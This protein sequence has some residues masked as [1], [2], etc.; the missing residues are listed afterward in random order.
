MLPNVDN[1]TI[2]TADNLDV[3][4]ELHDDCIDL[5]YLD[6]PF[7]SQR[8]Y[9]DSFGYREDLRIGFDD[10][11]RM[12]A[13]KQSWLDEIEFIHPAVFAVCEAAKTSAGTGMQGYL[14]FMAI[15]IIE[16]RRILKPTG[17]IYLHCDHHASHYLKLMMDAIFGK[18]N[19]RNDIAWGYRTGGV[20]KRYWP[21]KHDTILFYV[22]SNKYRHNPPQERVIYEK[23]FFNATFDEQGRPYADVYI[24]D[25]WDDIKPIINTSKERMGWPTQKPLALLDRIIRASSNPGDVVLDPFSGCATAC[26]ASERLERRWFGIDIAPEAYKMV[27][28]R[29]QRK[30]ATIAVPDGQAT[31]SDDEIWGGPSPTSSR[32]PIP[33]SA[34]TPDD[35]TRPR[36]MPKSKAGSTKNRTAGAPPAANLCPPKILRSTTSSPSQWAAAT[37]SPTSSSYATTATPSRATASPTRKSLKSLSS[38]ASWQHRSNTQPPEPHPVCPTETSATSNRRE[39]LDPDIGAPWSAAG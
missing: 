35:M 7:N 28:D 25:F 19:F 4:R 17:S 27:I 26:I 14:A 10:V 12:D 34:S 5:I 3:L 30:E 23:P 1:R 24:R 38:A 15:R 11:W 21:R 13:E 20:S 18:N 32:S 29:L 16:M 22:K 31:L 37:T 2:F 36:P 39:A 6:P 33:Y 8:R 9:F